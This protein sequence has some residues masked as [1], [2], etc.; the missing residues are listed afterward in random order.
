MQIASLASHGRISEHG[1]VRSSAGDSIMSANVTDILSDEQRRQ[2][3]IE[4]F[5]EAGDY[6]EAVTLG[7]D[8]AHP[9]DPCVSG[10]QKPENP[11]FD[12]LNAS[13]LRKLSRHP[14][15][16]LTRRAVCFW[17]P[18]SDLCLPSL[19]T[20]RRVSGAGSDELEEALEDLM[21]AFLYPCL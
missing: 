7:W 6:Q 9:P 17:A 18:A 20:S 19:I 21:L 15:G 14:S 3:W 4:H 2:A 13:H 10:H 5:V 11:P 16:C 12:K 1:A 8:F